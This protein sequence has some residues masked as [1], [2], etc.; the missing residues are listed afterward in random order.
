MAPTI[1]ELL[2][3]PAGT[4]N[5]TTDEFIELYNPNSVPFDLTGFGLQVGITSVHS[6]MFTAGT[7]TLPPQSF[8]AFYSSTTGLSLSNS[9]GQAKLIDPFGNSIAATAVYGTAKDGQSWAL[10]NGKWYWTTK[11]TP[12]AAN[13]IN[14]PPAAGKKSSAASKST[15]TTAKSKTAKI[16]KVKTKPV[17]ASHNSAD[18]V[19][20]TPIHL[21][22]LALV[23]GLALLYGAYEYRADLANRIYQLR[24]YLEARRSGGA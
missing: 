7:T 23:A 2:P 15:K 20:T 6:Y 8:T 10:A 24:R 17:T 19:S 5:D 12:G 4:G 22:T 14:Q 11:L 18:T 21:W 13:V 1:T 16:K 3:N 9:G